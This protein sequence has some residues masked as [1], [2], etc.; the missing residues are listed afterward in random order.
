MQS[1][2]QRLLVI[3]KIVRGILLLPIS[4][5]YGIVITTR[6]WL[7]DRGLIKVRKLPCVVI[8][9]GNLSLGGTGKTPFSL[10]LIS[11]FRKRGISVAYLSRG[12]K[13]VTRGFLEVSL[14]GLEPARRYGDEA[15]M[16]KWY[17]PE[18][19]VA[20]CEDR[21]SGG[22]RLLEKYPDLKVVILDDAFQ[23][24]QLH[25][26]LEILVVDSMRPPWKDW[27]FPLGRL[28]EPLH[29]Y[30]RA[31]LLILNYRTQP[32]RPLKY[33]LRRPYLSFLYSPSGLREAFPDLPPLSLED[34]RYKSCI[35]FCGIAHPQSFYET[36]R[37]LQVYVLQKFEFPDH[38]T[39]SLKVTAR[40]AYFYWRACRK[41]Q[42]SDLLLLTTEKDLI[43]L[44]QSP[45]VSALTD[46]PLY[47]L[48]IQMQPFDTERAENTLSNLLSSFLN[49]DHIRSI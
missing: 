32:Y 22:K 39:F 44:Y 41:Y 2:R 45:A 35:A 9:I 13:R 23:H 31:H 24:R 46:I 10:Y 11:W 7:Y 20:V 48:Q 36:L 25:R 14:S 28:R 15:A 49:Y 33:H 18:I 42:L 27:L 12:Y 30:H 3:I 4:V 16:V 47:A 19:P 1:L 37:N 8:S 17:F 29:S 26:D 34:I 38:Y 43:R 5:L 40:L 21:Y 6:N